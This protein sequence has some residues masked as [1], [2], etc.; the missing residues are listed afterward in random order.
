[1]RRA[2]RKPLL[3]VLH[4]RRGSTRRQRPMP[5]PTI[6]PVTP[7]RSTPTA[8]ELT[9]PCAHGLVPLDVGQMDP[10]TPIPN[11][12]PS[13]PPTPPP[14]MAPRRELYARTHRLSTLTSLTTD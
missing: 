9:V 13:R 12:K 1:M 5:E 3:S 6:D 8:A 11:P 14:I 4:P 7:P 2:T 10:W